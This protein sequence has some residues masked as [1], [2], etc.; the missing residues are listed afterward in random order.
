MEKTVVAEST[1]ARVLRWTLLP[2]GC[3]LLGW[4]LQLLASWLVTWKYMLFRGILETVDSI[5]APWDTIGSLGIGLVGGLVLA[6]I[7]E[8]ESLTATV[9]DDEVTLSGMDRV[10]TFGRADVAAVFFDRKQL[11]LLGHD[12]GELDRRPCDL[13]RDQVAD[14]FREHGYPWTDGDP[15]ADEYR[16][17]V[18][19]MPGPPEGANALLTA[20]GKKDP[21]SADARELRGE[22]ARLGVVVRDE[23]RKQYWRVLG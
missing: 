20:R 22:L 6:G 8:H 5:P 12:T 19:D 15:H 10:S 9:G 21:T 17:W 4:S 14:A 23:K 3:A 18:P 16:R 2:V 11:V 7:G 13:G 1:G